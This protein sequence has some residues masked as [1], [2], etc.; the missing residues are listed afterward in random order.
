MS[1]T[2][3][4]VII[5][6]ARTP[7]I[8]FK[9]ALTPLTA[10]QLGA[11]AI[12]AALE[13]TGVGPEQVDA[14]IMGQV[15]QAGAGQGPARQASILAGIGWDVP[16]VT[17]NKLCLSGLTA[18]IDAARL[19]RSGE[20]ELV[21]AGGQESMTNVPHVLVGSRQGTSVGDLALQ[22]S[23]NLDG[24]L[25]PFDHLL[26]GRATDEGNEQRRIPRAVQDAFAAQ[27]QQ[28]AAAARA[29]GTFAAEIAPI[30]VPQRR[31]P[32]LILTEDD[33]IRAETTQEILAGLRPAFRP[34]GS[35]TAGT[36][37]SSPMAQRS[38]SSPTAAGR[39]ATDS[40]GSPRSVRPARSPA[41]TAPC[42]PNPRERSRRRSIVTG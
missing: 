24:L 33:G 14:V 34:S 9:G 26:M 41:R 17:I 32:D 12:R 13:R 8:K 1:E 11:A 38:S 15:L 2:R 40:H 25:D 23:L 16:S 4:P 30:A 6:G 10:P 37:P 39:S 22:D 19:V 27:S 20:A 7:F 36:R 21:I 3:T 18:V 31:G 42:T 29:R 28:R 35:I 5:G